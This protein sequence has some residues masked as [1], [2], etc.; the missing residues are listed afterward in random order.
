MSDVNKKQTATEPLSPLKQA[1][2][3]I[4]NLQ[5]E[6]KAEKNRSGE[7]IAIIGMSCRLPGAVESP[8]QFWE[9]LLGGGDGIIHQQENNNKDYARW[10]LDKFLDPDRSAKGKSITLDAG[11]MK[12][13]DKFDTKFFGI[14]PREAESMD[15]QQRLSL[16]L[17]H[18]A[19]QDAGY[20]LRALEGSDTG[21]YF[22]VGGT[23]YFRFCL[24]SENEDAGFFVTG[25]TQ[26]VISGRVA[27]SLGL[28]GPAVAIDT[29]CSSS[30]VAIH[31]A[32]NA[33][34]KGECKAAFAGGVNLLLDPQVF[35]SLSKANMLAPDGRCKT[36]DDSADGYVRGEGGAVLMLKTLSQAK[37]DGDRIHAV[38]CG[39]AVNQDGRSSSLTAP[40]GPAQQKVIRKALVDAQL[41]PDSVGYVECH[42]TGTSL[43]DPIEVHAL[44]AVYGKRPDRKPLILGALKS[45]I[46]HLEAASGVASI[47]KVILSLKHK[48][49]PANL[50][51][52]KQNRHFDIEGAP[53]VFA[54]NPIDW[55]SGESARYAG[56][57]SFGFSGT[58]CHMIIGAAPADTSIP[59]EDVNGRQVDGNHLLVLSAKTPAALKQQ[60]ANYARLLGNNNTD[61]HD[62]CFSAAVMRDQYAQ[63]S[64][65]A[66]SNREELIAAI[67][68]FAESDN[69]FA[70][71]DGQKTV[72][73]IGFMFT[74]QGAQHAGMAHQLYQQEKVFREALDRCVAVLKPILPLPLLDVLWGEHREQLDQTAYTQ[75]ALFCIEYSLAILLQSWGITPVA[76]MGHSVGEYA[77]ACIAGIFSLE[78]CV[79]LIAERG[80]LMQSLP[81]GGGMMVVMADRHYVQQLLAT[82][83]TTQQQCLVSIGAFNAETQTVL[84]GNLEVLEELKKHC[85]TDAVAMV[86]LAV[87]HGFHSQLMQPILQ[88]FDDF[89]ATIRF[90][91]P[92][93][94]IISNVT[95][96]VEETL[97]QNKSYWVE[98][99][100]APV[101]FFEGV[102]NFSEEVDIVIEV[103]PKPTLTGLAKRSSNKASITWL[104]SLKGDGKDIL[105]LQ[106]TLASLY[107]SGTDI[108]W[109][110]YY[111][112]A[113]RKG[114]KVSLPVY[115]YQ[116]QRFWI[117]SAGT[118]SANQAMP[119]QQPK[120]HPLLGSRIAIPG[121]LDSY[122]QSILSE[123]S[124]AYLEHHR[125]FNTVIVP[126]ASHVSMAISAIQ[127]RYQSRQCELGALAFFQ[128]IGVPDGGSRCAQ[129][130]LSPEQSTLPQN[131]VISGAFK[132]VSLTEETQK[133]ADHA[134]ET[135][136]AGIFRSDIVDHTITL[137]NELAALDLA[138]LGSAWSMEQSGSDFYHSIWQRGYTLGSAFCW[139]GDRWRQ[140]DLT[141][142]AIV[143]PDLPESLI[144]YPIYPGLVD[145]CFQAFGSSVPL[146]AE[147]DEIYIPF[148]V[149]NLKFFNQP[150][151]SERLWCLSKA[152]HSADDIKSGKAR[153]VGDLVLFNESGE[154]F[155]DVAGLE[156]RKSSARLLKASLPGAQVKKY[157]YHSDWQ[158][159]PTAPSPASSEQLILIVGDKST[160]AIIDG[161]GSYFDER[162]VEWISVIAG[163]TFARV[164]ANC[165]EL[166]LARAEDYKTLFTQLSEKGFPEIGNIINLLPSDLHSA[167]T[168]QA[169]LLV[170]SLRITALVNTCINELDKTPHIAMVSQRGQQLGDSEPLSPVQHAVWSIY[171]VLRIEQP[172]FQCRCFDIVDG[173]RLDLNLVGADILGKDKKEVEVVY[174]NGQ[175][176]VHRINGYHPINEVDTSLN[177]YKA[178]TEGT[179]VISGALGG[180][181]FEMIQWL[182]K[183]GAR[184]LALLVRREPSAAQELILGQLRQQGI[185]IIC[186]HCDLVDAAQIASVL[187]RIN[188]NQ[189]RVCGVFHLAGVLDDKFIQQQDAHSYSKV[190]APK[191]QATYNL[192]LATRN[193]DVQ[194]FVC[195]SSIAAAFGTPGQGNYAAANAYMDALMRARQQEGYVGLSI[196]WGPWA[197]VGMAA[198][199]AQDNNENKMA[200]VG[201]NA[202]DVYQGLNDMGALLVQASNNNSA[203][204]AVV[205]YADL[206][207]A[208]FLR[209]FPAADTNPL[210]SVY[211]QQF[212][213]DD[214]I[215]GSYFT[216]LQEAPVG[217]RKNLLTEQIH[218]ILR[219]IMKFSDDDVI[220]LDTG[221]FDSGMDSLMSLEFRQKLEKVYNI[222]LP[223]TVAFNYP[224]I[225]DLLGYF[226]NSAIKLPFFDTDNNNAQA[227]P[228]SVAQQPSEHY[229]LQEILA[230]DLSEADLARLL[231]EQLAEM[232]AE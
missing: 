69:P 12:D 46:G 129:I 121:A 28:Q 159:V 63:R 95:A 224:T 32:V 35:V 5:E 52:K 90:A 127:D 221:F 30:L 184:H 183:S 176:Y 139:V 154:V 74:G 113:A 185:G 49:I 199:L 7:A 208:Q 13:H 38:I 79:R 205:A 117:Q 8:D 96:N 29:A 73:R 44:D 124:P 149:E 24:E 22:G 174:R 146:N 123:H 109:S 182:V 179:Y 128:T 198:A 17:S 138:Q 92:G 181:G 215:R 189:Q 20:T 191:V 147:N 111:A 204:K 114:N 68:Q 163:Q 140:G 112:S 172:Q 3:A 130:I 175:R 64:A 157:F 148:S 133:Y 108:D 166:D 1:F 136:A 9:F 122:Y 152:H 217:E 56:V 216:L 132:V 178:D 160:Q 98:H 21:V 103:G 203:G 186:Y 51:F 227:I 232:A 102:K 170:Q 165:F 145:S 226:I 55:E 82:K 135:N 143:L 85:E 99:I 150:K 42:G 75:P 190:F 209:N 125:L 31:L 76:V 47:I 142:H 53:L 57:S 173:N 231:D 65:F 162:D 218:N 118:Y 26:N 194:C 137:K 10:P 213:S 151:P 100:S 214:T 228:E 86:S 156:L 193:S 200:A 88:Q 223:P 141:L 196:N 37:K 210:F 222:S 87:S 2:I 212:S 195:F 48:K 201:M 41:T 11:L 15:P 115:P 70:R 229:A 45:N 97:L 225:G 110:G 171:R 119:S 72:P 33:L 80:R 62:V 83:I 116:R 134:W 50:H 167:P 105:N 4:E 207:W 219:S 180:I 6:L 153:Y 202:F 19:A 16:E 84:S 14:A 169:A 93:I 71:A 91:P 104:T 23:E 144:P 78:D 40:N 192:D 164:S 206:N 161:L 39:S 36:F 58:N 197:N 168:P 43:G 66:E 188:Q 155:M 59:A 94:K 18:T 101:N 106:K 77:A 131:T 34:R 81:A 60:A 220:A 158:P 25:N 107:Q 54:D 230:S 89:L 120:D 27:F 61:L 211:Q 67:Q 126:G 177:Q 187:S